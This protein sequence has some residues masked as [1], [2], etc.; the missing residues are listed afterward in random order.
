VGSGSPLA[1]NSREKV[2]NLNADK[3]DGMDAEAFLAANGIAQDAAHADRADTSAN[4]DAL[5][6]KDSSEFYA[7]GSKVADSTHADSADWAADAQK[8]DGR[9]AYE[10]RTGVAEV[11]L[12]G[13]AILV[14]AL[15]EHVTY[16]SLS[17]RIPFPGYL[18]LNG[19]VTFFHDQSNIIPPNPN[20]VPGSGMVQ[21]VLRRVVG[22][23]YVDSVPSYEDLTGRQYANLALDGVF[24]VGEGEETVEIWLARGGGGSRGRTDLRAERRVDCRVR[25]LQPVRLGALVLKLAGACPLCVDVGEERRVR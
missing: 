4:A 7:V 10:F 1:V 23:G 5:D 24:F 22:D 16:G 8:L 11:R 12:E 17:I 21:G 25:F 19:N 20:V 14:P 6:G 3:L 2:T 15:P 9:H 18:R 13:E